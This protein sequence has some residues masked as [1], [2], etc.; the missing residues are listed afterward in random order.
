MW[1]PN[2]TG[3]IILEGW[4]SE[5]AMVV[6]T[7]KGSMYMK[8]LPLFIHHLN[9]FVRRFVSMDDLYLL[10]LDGHGS[11]KGRIGYSSH[12]MGIVKLFYPEQIP[13]TSCNRAIKT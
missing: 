5:G 12:L 7:A 11:R 10:T 1:R 2:Q 13:H 9:E 3:N 4:F 6:T 8:V